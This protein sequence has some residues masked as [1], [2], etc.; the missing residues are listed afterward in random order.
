MRRNLA[1]ALTQPW[2]WFALAFLLVAAGFYP[3]FFGVLPTID[4]VHL[5][6]GSAATAWMLLPLLQYRL[7]RSGQRRLHRIVGYFSLALAATVVVTGLRVV[8]LMVSNKSL[9]AMN[10]VRAKFT[11]LDLTGLLLFC[12]FLGLA[13]QAARRRDIGLHVRLLACTALIPLEAALERLWMNV[14]PALIPDFGAGLYAALFTMEAFCVGIVAAEWRS[15]RVRWPLPALLAYYLAMHIFATPIASQPG[16]QQFCSWF[17][18][19][20]A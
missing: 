1:R 4:T 3:S 2:P 16:F 19:L 13:I 17:A 12:V 9:T 18:Q 5:L 14:F 10:F 6:H 7:V 15:G 20:G 8:Q 11:L